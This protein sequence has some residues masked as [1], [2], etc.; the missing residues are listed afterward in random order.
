MR[1]PNTAT[2]RLGDLAKVV[3]SKNAKPYRLTL[4]ILF[5]DPVVFANVRDSGALTARAVAEAYK[6]PESE[7]LS[8]YVFDEGRAFKFTLRRPRPQGSIHES[9]MYGAQQHAPLLDIPIPF[10]HPDMTGA[11]PSQ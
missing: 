5:D 1:E 3:R 8:S 10:E 7:V 6:I 2:V 9:D 4:D 11:G